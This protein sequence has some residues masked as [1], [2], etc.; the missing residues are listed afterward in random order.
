M[1]RFWKYIKPYLAAFIIGPIL[2][3]TEVV[4]EVALPAL[5]ANIIN[6]GAANQ[7]VGYIIGMGV[8]MILVA[9]MMMIGGCGRCLL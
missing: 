1:K 3:V 4:G 8:T 5:M 6:I 7:D 9:V 2:M